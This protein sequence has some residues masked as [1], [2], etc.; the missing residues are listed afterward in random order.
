MPQPNQAPGDGGDGLP[1]VIPPPGG[2]SGS[3]KQPG[4]AAPA[5]LT[6]EGVTYTPDQVKDLLKAKA[7]Y[8]QLQPEFTKRSQILSDPEKFREYGQGKFPDVFQPTSPP[9]DEDKQRKEA[10]ETLRG[11][12]FMTKEEAISAVREEQSMA[13]L[14][15]QFRTE[16]SK[17]E[18]DWDGKDGKPKFDFE[19]VKK[20]LLD[21]N[22]PTLKSAFNDLYGDAIDE[23]KFAHRPA[24]PKPPVIAAPG[25]SSAVPS[26]KKDDHIDL[27]RTGAVR[28]DFLKHLETSRSE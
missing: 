20:H 24:K 28:E 8:D 9:T 5:G 13:R 26:P 7:D 11:L 17:L 21:N 23:W 12:G 10:V 1:P 16:R 3:E 27:T 19:V 2:Q 6:I 18:T 22:F 14:T 25:G 4:D 15:E